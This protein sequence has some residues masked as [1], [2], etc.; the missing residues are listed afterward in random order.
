MALAA[1]LWLWW[2]S[3]PVVRQPGEKL[4]EI[5]SRLS[6]DL[7]EDA[8]RP[9]FVDAGEAAGL[10]DFRT[11]TGERTSQ[12]PED[13]GAGVAWGDFDDDGDDDLFLVGAGGPL[14]SAEVPRA[15]SVLYE[16]LSERGAP[17]TFRRSAAFPETRVQGMAAAWGDA[18]GDGRPDLALTGYNV[19]R[20]YQNLGGRLEASP[21]LPDLPGYWA[22]AAWGD[23]DADGDLDLYVCGYVRYVEDAGSSRQVSD[24]YGT[25][26]PYTLNPAAFE[27]ER[28]L[29]FE[30]LSTPG[31][32]RFEEV[33]V[34][35]GVSNP[36]GRSLSALW[37]DF[38]ADGRLD[39]YVA[40][41]I[42]DNALYL[43]RGETFEDAGLSAWVADYRG[44]MG[45]AAGDW[46]RDGDD[47]LFV[48][49]WLAQENALYDS[50]RVDL[51]AAPL[52]FSDL[53]A[54][55]GL[56]QVALQFVGWGTAMADFDG[57]GWQDLVVANG[58][59]LETSRDGSAKTLKPQRS[60]LFWSQ[61]GEHFHDLAPYQEQLA[62]PRVSRGL[63]VADYDRDGDLDLLIARLDA[64]PLLLA[65]EM[66]SGHWI[67]L[68]LR[69]ETLSSG[70][71]STAIVEVGGA[72]L[73]RTVGGV[74]YLSQSSR[75][76]HF[77]LGDVDRIDGVTV[78]WLGGG[79]QSFGPLPIDGFW[80]LT[81]GVPEARR[82]PAR[83]AVSGADDGTAPASTDA[84]ADERTRRLAFWE[85]QRAAMDAF[86]RDGDCE[87][88]V[89]LFREALS[90]DP[91]HEDSSYY[92]ANCLADLGDVPGALEELDRLRGID[93]GSHRAHKQ[94]GVLRAI[95]ARDE[96]DLLAAEAAL[97]RAHEINKEEIGSLQ[98]LGEIAVL[99]GDDDLARQRFEWVCQTHA[100]SVGALFLRAYLRWS[101]GDVAASRE[102]LVV[103]R[104]ARG[105]DWKPE[106]AVAE[107]DVRIRM[108]R[109]GSL[110]ADYWEHWDGGVDDPGSVFASLHGDLMRRRP[111]S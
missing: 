4:E 72:R 39:L 76:L 44:A 23:F 81:Q 56:G 77:G 74:S 85:T 69:G 40:N 13:M 59:T 80:E 65:N 96:A 51:P 47:D 32:P 53:A 87:A 43:N 90:L 86:K 24:Q 17:V 3:R 8:P 95:S 30:N 49:H 106:G 58:S 27:P 88:A 18:D 33:A 25:A 97:E 93:P 91:G 70:D 36:G 103:A 2:S 1:G 67:A 54:P 34:L 52:A 83:G 35:W 26:V 28:N 45:L 64:P 82:L 109:E 20:L 10:G 60:M 111:S 29:L 22:G 16:N 66:Q 61:R 38:D 94:W 105:A 6:R 110:L 9:N 89:P 37:W 84:A 68:K 14:G 62:E 92:L 21:A 71:G 7:P 79:E 78:R 42:S 107:G 46:N 11:W 12:L 99:R 50:R 19:L 98:V 73:R 104:E 75:V 57:D 63:A 31:E 55:L 101:Q 5:T 100:R 108:H 15:E 48:T 41:D 102:L